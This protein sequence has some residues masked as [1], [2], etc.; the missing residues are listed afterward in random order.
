MSVSLLTISDTKKFVKVTP[1]EH[2]I[3]DRLCNDEDFIKV[4]RGINLSMIDKIYKI[5]TNGEAKRGTKKYYQELSDLIYKIG[6][7]SNAFINQDVVGKFYDNYE[8]NMFELKCIERVDI[9]IFRKIFEK[10]KEYIIDGNEYNNE[11]DK[12]KQNNEE[13]CDCLQGVNDDHLNKIQELTHTIQI[14]IRDYYLSL[15][16]RLYYDNFHKISP[17]LSTSESKDKAKEF[18]STPHGI[19]FEY[20]IPKKYLHIYAIPNTMHNEEPIIKEIQNLGLP[21]IQNTPYVEEQ[22]YCIKR[23]LFSHL[24]LSLSFYNN[25]NNKT[26]PIYT[27]I[28]PH[29][30]KFNKELGHFEIHQM[31][32]FEKIRTTNYYQYSEF[33]PHEA[34]FYAKP[35][36]ATNET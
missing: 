13:F 19:I 24:M 4:Y 1:C 9:D 31:D 25:D 10:L 12:F 2:E 35:I 20:M 3:Y 23:G 33:N 6:Y 29:I 8:D 22:E 5:E 17:L 18:I 11:V 15:L 32:F 34:T 26:Q 36:N 28:N 21:I 30:E 7:K 14:S 27:I 16:H